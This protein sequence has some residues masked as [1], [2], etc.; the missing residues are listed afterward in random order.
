LNYTGII[1]AGFSGCFVKSFSP[2]PSSLP[3]T[4][5]AA[6]TT[7]AATTTTTTILT[8]TVAG[9]TTTTTLVPVITTATLT[10]PSLTTLAS[11]PPLTTVVTLPTVG[12]KKRQATSSP[13]IA[14][15]VISFSGT[16]SNTTLDQI[17]TNATTGNVTTN[18]TSL[19]SSMSE[20]IRYIIFQSILF[21]YFLLSHSVINTIS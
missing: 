20:F 6:A 5:T 9:Q 1:G 14:D 15:T 18:I 3:P 10:V 19:D 16:I 8:T 17:V 12:R 4:T 7:A 2:D 21:F 13:I 11:L